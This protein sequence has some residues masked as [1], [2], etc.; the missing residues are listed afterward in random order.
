MTK[1]ELTPVHLSNVTIEGPF[2]AQRTKINRERT[3]PRLYKIYQETGQI[4]SLKLGWEPSTVLEPRHFWYG[5]VYQWIEA[6]SY[7]LTKHPDAQLDSLIDG[8]VKLIVKRQEP[9]GYMP[10]SYKDAVPEKHLRTSLNSIRGGLSGGL[11]EAGVA[12]F[13]ATGKR[14]LLDVACRHAD[15]IDSVFGS[16]PG[17]KPGYPEHEGTEMSLIKLYQATGERR[18]ANLAKFFVDERG[19]QPHYFDREAIEQGEDPTK[20]RV[21]TY[22]YNQSHKPVREQDRAVGHAVRATYLYSA[23]AEVAAE[24]G[25]EELRTA[26][27]RLW[28]NLTLKQMY[29]TG[30]IGPARQNEGF[31]KDYDLPNTTAYCETCAAIGLV[32]WAHRMLQFEC[33]GRYADIME[34]A[35]YNGALSGVSL[36][37][38]KFF[39]VNPLT[40][41][42]NHHRQEWFEC[43]CCPPNIMRLIASLGNYV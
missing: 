30:G 38:E 41:L 37:G 33:D 10:P 43:P 2:W 7:S 14:T 6:A 18:Y 15:Y 19:Q 42:G 1:K 26:C 11:F 13:Q 24:F 35:L 25:D 12:H 16:E 20:F 17:K 31:T 29:I 36:D 32:L 3:I 23:M 5:G 22:E 9:D 4:N 34:R 27:D 28:D 40:S 8:L 21:R 39:Y